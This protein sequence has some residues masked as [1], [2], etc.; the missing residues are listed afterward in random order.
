M[1][2]RSLTATF[3][4]D[5]PNRYVHYIVKTEVAKSGD[6][7]LA[8]PRREKIRR[9]VIY[10]QR[11]ARDSKHLSSDSNGSEKK[12]GSLCSLLPQR[13]LSMEHRSAVTLLRDSPAATLLS[14]QLIGKERA[15][16]VGV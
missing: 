11:P 5:Q 8:L 7:P 9:V 4:W 12:H 2:Y 3:V 13:P 1:Q 16:S 14:A 6:G 15:A 10:E